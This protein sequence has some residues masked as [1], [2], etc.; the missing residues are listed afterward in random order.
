[1]PLTLAARRLGLQLVS[2]VR[3]LDSGLNRPYDYDNLA[4]VFVT[5]PP[6]PD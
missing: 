4:Q 1:M 3:L 2:G 5:G 6:S